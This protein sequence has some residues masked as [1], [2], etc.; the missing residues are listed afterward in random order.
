MHRFELRV[1][2][3]MG[4]APMSLRGIL[5]LYRAHPVFACFG[6]SWG[7]VP[8]PLRFVALGQ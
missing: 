7:P 2:S 6:G 1:P 5:P 8:K 3:S 4:V